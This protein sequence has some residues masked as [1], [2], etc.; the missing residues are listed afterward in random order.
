MLDTLITTQNV[1][2]GVI[3]MVSHIIGVGQFL[4][5][6]HT[7]RRGLFYTAPTINL[8]WICLAAAPLSVVFIMY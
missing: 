4:L 8:P 1:E 2:I 5:Q 7:F 6:F 3:C